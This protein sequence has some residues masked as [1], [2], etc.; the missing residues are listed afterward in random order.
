MS[1]QKVN[2][3]EYLFTRLYQLGVKDLH[4]VPGD[5]NLVA[6][7]YVEPCG[8]NWVGNCNELNAGRVIADL[9]VWDDWL[10]YL[11]ICCRRIWST[12]GYGRFGD[13]IRGGRQVISLPLGDDLELMRH[14]TV[15]SQRD[16]WVLC[17]VLPCCTHCWNAQESS[18]KE[19][20]ASASHGVSFILLS[21][22][23]SC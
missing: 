9:F 12:V 11:R 2:V 23:N 22:G 3:A 21:E 4:G 6:L 7:D 20:H 16:S 19:W 13:N 10:I 15:L 17:R 5:F 8:I 14:R 18:S 1:G